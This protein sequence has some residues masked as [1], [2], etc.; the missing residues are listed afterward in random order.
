M[1]G[2]IPFLDLKRINA[3]HEPGIRAGIDR[4][5]NSGWYVLGEEVAAFEREFA[6]YC[7]A[8]H[9]IGVA[10][11]LDALHLLLRAYGIGPGDEVIVPSN[12][13]IA[14]WLAVSQAGARP[15]P[16]E[17]DHRTHNLDPRL[18]KAAI[19]PRTRAIMPVHLYGQPAEMDAIM[20]IAAEHGLKV[21]EDAAQAHGARYRG[22]RTGSLGDAAGF[23]FY[24]GKNLGALG[25]GGAITT[26]DEALAAKL[27]MLRNYGSSIKYKHE[28]AGV[29]SRL[30]EIQAAVLRAKLPALDEENA[31]R[32]RVAALYLQA[33]D[34]LPLQLPQV[35]D[36]AEPVWHLMVVATPRRAA[37]QAALTAAQIGH[38]V[39]YPTACHQ[40]QAY[41]DQAWPALPM[42]ERLQH[43]VLSLPIAPYMTAEEVGRVAA[44]IRAVLG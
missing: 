13:F 44:V 6:D 20:A 9:C 17:P 33:L 42:A 5:L 41:A 16:V 4:V 29:N 15:V 10:D 25:D 11:G 38:L 40:Q 28:M 23:S 27:R 43:E 37:L 24:P 2:A 12:T 32:R 14:T 31:A 34:G 39:H 36:G 21:I 3:A 19:T 8:K 30:D 1:A 22:R 18:I 26:D 7:E 35:A